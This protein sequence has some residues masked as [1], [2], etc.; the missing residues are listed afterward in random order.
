V[1][2]ISI[3]I[4]GFGQHDFKNGVTP[5]E[6]MSETKGISSDSIICKVDGVLTDLSASLSSNCE[7]QFLDAKS[8][9]GHSVLLHSTAHLMAQAVKRLFP[10]TKVTIGPF[11]EN[12]FY[13][14][15]DVETPFTEYD[16]LKIEE[17]MLKISEENLSILHQ[18]K[19]QTEAV[20]FFESINETYKVEIIN[21]LGEDETLKVYSQGEFTDLCRGPHVPSTGV[22]KHFKLLASSAAYWRGDENNQ[23]L[24]RVYGTSF[25][26]KKDLKKYLLM[27]EEQKKRDHRKIGKE[28]DL[29]FFDEEV[30]PGLPLWTPNGTVLIDELEA[31]ANKMETAS[32]YLRVRTPHLTKGELYEKSGHLD[33]YISSMYSAMDVDG[34]DYYM[35]PMN[36]P[37]HHKI[38]ANSPKSYR[39]LPYRLSEYGTCYRYEKSG[40]L[41]GLMR[42]RSMQMNDGHIYCTEEQFKD[43]FIDVCNLY[44]KYFKIFGIEKYEMRLSLHDP[45]DL[46][47]KFIDNPTLWKKTEDDVRNALKGAKLKFVESVGDAAFYGPKIDVQVWSSIGREFTLATNQ[48]DFAVPDRFDLN[49]TDKDGSSKTPLCIHRAPLGTH[50]RFIGFLIEHFGG[51]FPLWLAP[52]QVTILPVSDKYNEYAES[53]TKELKSSG[54]R[55]SLD[56]RSEKIGSKIR[57]A[58]MQKINIMIIVG[59]KE[60]QNQT[61][62]IRRRFVKEQKELSLQEFSKDILSEIKERRVS[63]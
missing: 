23:T 44:I 47:K 3:N 32:G 1:S 20:K 53:I 12:R 16:L 30:G 62:T 63:N 49:Y 42:V 43:E 56:S 31:L 54:V 50:E 35:K 55:A 33:H 40:E 18:K 6:I 52:K 34:I 39:D 57:D 5:L 7:L 38:F 19:S 27:L 60:V 9:D 2:N 36:C 51:N 14:D 15:F 13:Y 29:Y 41:F 17:E 26:N 22:I 37:H 8:K 10:K 58:E 48:V 45:K 24:Q 11:L 25:Q 21:D 61:V 28:L 46:G 59:E 4:K